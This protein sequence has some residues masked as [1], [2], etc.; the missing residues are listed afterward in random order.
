MWT[1]KL[2]WAEVESWVK[3][4]RCKEYVPPKLVCAYE[5][6]R[7]HN[8]EERLSAFLLGEYPRGVRDR[9][10]H[11]WSQV[12]YWPGNFQPGVSARATYKL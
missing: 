4:W 11:S 1:N 3:Y 10:N 8:P 5:S 9:K 12:P 2:N 6:T 7:R